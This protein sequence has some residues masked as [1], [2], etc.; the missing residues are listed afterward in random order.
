M[1]DYEVK[2]AQNKK[3]IKQA[4]RLR[5]EIFSQETDRVSRQAENQLDV[6]DYDKFCD[7]LIVIDKTNN[8]IVG[9]YRLL[10]GSKVDKK[11]GFYSEKSFN[12]GNIKKLAVDGEMLELGRACIHHDY[13]DRLVINLLWSGISKYIKHYNVRF[14]FGAVRLGTTQPLEVSRMFKLIK[15]K[16][17]APKDYRVYPKEANVFKGLDEN[18][19]I[20]DYIKDYQDIWRTLSPLAKGYLRAGVVVCG[21]PAVNPDFGSIVVFILLDVKTMSPSY[22]RHFF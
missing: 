17:Y 4:L 16:F 14:V 22:K 7:H 1:F 10:L 9:T 19:E 6:D 15:K 20:K 13:R 18:V 8:K 5:Y 12:I 3:E 2:I 11:I 21:P